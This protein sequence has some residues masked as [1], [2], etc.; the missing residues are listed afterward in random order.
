M[1]KRIASLLTII[2]VVF[3]FVAPV[4]AEDSALSSNDT[5]GRA[6]TVYKRS[7]TKSRTFNGVSVTIQIICDEYNMG[8]ISLITYTS[9]NCKVVSVS[10]GGVTL[11]G[12][13]SDGSAGNGTND[14][15][16][17]IIYYDYI[18]DFGRTGTTSMTFTIKGTSLV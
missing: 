11:I 6:G 10:G 12:D 17:V 5:V 1:K 16:K 2:M 14:E 18:N 9:G 8:G 3:A 15:L 13:Y 7:Y 4:K